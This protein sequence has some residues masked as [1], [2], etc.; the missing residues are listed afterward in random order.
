VARPHSTNELSEKI[1]PILTSIGSIR[2][3]CHNYES[4]PRLHPTDSGSRAGG[5]TDAHERMLYRYPTK[6]QVVP[7]LR[8]GPRS[9][10]DISMWV[11]LY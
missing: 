7:S 3:H 8:L 6:F 11:I 5:C 10:S 2:R 9:R 1:A 4:L